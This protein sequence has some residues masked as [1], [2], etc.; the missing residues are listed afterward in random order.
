MFFRLGA[1]KARHVT[2]V[3]GGIIL[4]IAHFARAVLKSDR[5]IHPVHLLRAYRALTCRVLALL[6]F[7]LAFLTTTTIVKFIGLAFLIAVGPII[8]FIAK[9]AVQTICAFEASIF[10]FN[11]VTRAYTVIPVLAFAYSIHSHVV[12][13]QIC[14]A[15]LTL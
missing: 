2:L 10:A 1:M 14:L 8:V 3:T 6:A 13:I 5:H 11:A 9:A 7:F 12:Q 4:V 15:K